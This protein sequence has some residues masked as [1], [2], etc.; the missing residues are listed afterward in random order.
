ME[1]FKPLLQEQR[2]EGS[3][4]GISHPP[5]GDFKG[6]RDSEIPPTEERNAPTHLDLYGQYVMLFPVVSDG[7]TYFARSRIATTVQPLSRR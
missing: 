3:P 7:S 2:Y 5:L 1:T 6:S 4:Y